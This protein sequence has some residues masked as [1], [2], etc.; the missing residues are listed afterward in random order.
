MSLPSFALTTRALRLDVT[1]SSFPSSMYDKTKHEFSA[2]VDKEVKI[3]IG[4]FDAMDGGEHATSFKHKLLVDYVPK[5]NA[6]GKAELSVDG[7]G[8]TLLVLKPKA[9][10]D[11][12][13]R[14]ELRISC[15]E[16][17]R[18]FPGS[19]LRF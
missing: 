6:C 10:S 2:E 9:V 15:H 7:Q 11:E 4:V 17:D 19:L 8:R 14:L 3:P 13:Y 5:E 16:I 1:A 12:A 18:E